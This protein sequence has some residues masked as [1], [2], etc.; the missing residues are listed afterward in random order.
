M[1]IRF[2]NKQ[3]IFFVILLFSCNF[4][5]SQNDS[6]KKDSKTSFGGVPI[7]SYDADLGL[8]YGAVVNYF[9]YN[10]RNSENYSE[11]VFLKVFNKYEAEIFIY[12]TNGAKYICINY[13]ICCC[14]I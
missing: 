4:L 5:Y 10:D 2:F 11:N 3:Y 9:K 6:L 7:L 8:R 13:G 1:K 14:T 12:D